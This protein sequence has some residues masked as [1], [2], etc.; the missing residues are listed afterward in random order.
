MDAGMTGAEGR[1]ATYGA[2]EL[3][4]NAENTAANGPLTLSIVVPVY[5]G[6]KYL[7][8]LVSEV[9]KLRQ[10]WL[11]ENAPLKIAELILVD[12]S[13]IDGSPDL[14][15]ALAA[16]VPWVRA[17]HNSTNYGQHAATIAGIVKTTGDWVVTMDED[18]QHPPSAIPDLLERV[19]RTRCDIVYARALGRSVHDSKFRDLSSRFYKR[20]I[21]WLTGNARI[22]K[23][24]SFRLIRGAIARAASNVCGHDTYFDV[25]LLWYT[26]RIETLKMVLKDA[27]YIETKKSG[28][29]IRS[30][31]SHARRMLVS[32]QVKL[33]RLGSLFG[34]L[35]VLAS[36][37]A[38]VV[39]IGIKV[40]DPQLIEVRGWIS[41]MLA[42]TGFGGAIMF[43]VGIVLE[44]MS[45]L[46]LKAHG[47]PLYFH[48]DRSS[49]RVLIEHYELAV[50]PEA[51]KA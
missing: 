28:Y 4:A 46:V 15:D 6:E 3:G 11:S 26:K 24:N 35:T 10:R 30:L 48:V 40:M 5:A 43:L 33:L 34:L 7:R 27:R 22:R 21:V 2:G 37:A 36:V 17:V 44:Y 47:R 18:L 29:S 45:I 32:S 31:L 50:A 1:G 9:E 51:V 16:E 14:V 41:I 25:A 8:A 19:A 13:A 38:A 23:A 42:I 12:D 20:V 39:L 49:D